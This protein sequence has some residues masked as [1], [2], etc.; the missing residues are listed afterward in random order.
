MFKRIQLQETH[1]KLSDLSV[2]RTLG[3]GMFGI[4]FLVIH[5][6]KQT[7]F[8][9]KTISRKKIDRFQI[10]ENMVLERK[11]LMQI[12][13]LMILKLIKTF[14][15][16]KRVYFLT[17]YVK[18]QDLFDVLREIGIVSENDSRFYLACLIVILE[19]LHERDIIYRDLKPENVMVDE[20]GYPKLIDFGT[21]KIVQSRTYT[22]VGT[23][24]YMA[25]EI[26]LGKG[27]SVA[28]DY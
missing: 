5:R 18:G 24:H 6:D 10:Y 15:D 7:L 28:V 26:I 25:P 12:D 16:E 1:V 13:H 8:A 4:V 21:A 3:K 9:L 20:D 23:P 27:Y 2:I 17:E 22:V 14:K 11:V 19:H